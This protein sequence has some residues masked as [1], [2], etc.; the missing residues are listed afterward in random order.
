MMLI[1]MMCFSRRDNAHIKV[2]ELFYTA[3]KA[4]RESES[5]DDMLQTLLDTKYKYEQ[6]LL[7][8]VFYTFLKC[9]TCLCQLILQSTTTLSASDKDQF[10]I[11]GI[12][13]HSTSCL[14]LSVSRY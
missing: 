10:P 8:C 1:V 3:I 6:Q 11:Q 2:K 12:Q 7:L 5:Q 13:Y 4:R 9:H 14:E